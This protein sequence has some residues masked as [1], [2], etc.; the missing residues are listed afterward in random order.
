MHMDAWSQNYKEEAIQQIKQ[1]KEHYKDMVRMSNVVAAK[2]CECGNHTADSRISFCKAC[3]TSF[4]MKH[5][6]SK[7]LL[8]ESCMYRYDL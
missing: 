8:C 2:Q 1:N 4:C 6:D 5:G 7:K 3:K